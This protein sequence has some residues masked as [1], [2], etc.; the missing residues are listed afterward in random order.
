VAGR[1]GT[2]A[3]VDVVEALVA[4]DRLWEQR[5]VALAVW[6][7]S[8][9]GMEAAG[10]RLRHVESSREV[11]LRQAAGGLSARQRAWAQRHASYATRPRDRAGRQVLITWTYRRARLEAAQ[12]RFAPSLDAART[13]LSDAERELA[14]ASAALLDVWGPSA[15]AAT[16]RSRRALAALARGAEPAR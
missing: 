13:L 2:V 6:R 5:A 8:L 4:H 9:A 15:A 3:V 14:T 16:G 7:R 12:A 10:Q 11:A 1:V